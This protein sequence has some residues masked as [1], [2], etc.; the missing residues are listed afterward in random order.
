MVKKRFS[1]IVDVH[2]LLIQNEKILLLLRK[3]TGYM[4]G[5]YHIPAGHLDG[6]ERI[7]R[8]LM[9]ES[10]EEIGI[11]IK[12][13]EVK[14]IQVM[15]NK[16]NVE[17]LAFFFEVKKWAGEIKNMEPEKCE[18]VKW[19]SLDNL[20]DKMV[21]YA[22]KAIEYYLEGIKMSYYGWGE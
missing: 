13:S 14:F 6:E 9:R 4:D 18:E 1:L 17:R 5:Y 11:D 2:L 7:V 20:P 22:K 21:P 19:F 3:N 15:H 8:A 16:S 12:E 10:K